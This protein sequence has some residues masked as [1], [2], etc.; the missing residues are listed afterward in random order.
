[1]LLWYYVFPLQRTG[2]YLVDEKIIYVRTFK[3]KLHICSVSTIIKV[4]LCFSDACKK[5]ML[6]LCFV[7]CTNIYMHR[8]HTSSALKGR[9]T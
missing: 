8:I 9:K 7:P 3:E 1:M 5:C 6:I 2:I 4:V